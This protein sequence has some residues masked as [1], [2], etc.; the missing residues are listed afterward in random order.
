MSGEKY[1]APYKKK[2]FFTSSQT[3]I[4]WHIIYNVVHTI[5]GKNAIYLKR[6]EKC[7]SL[8]FRQKLS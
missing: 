5:S 6:K 2:M 8:H 1:L 3:E 4:A 7:V